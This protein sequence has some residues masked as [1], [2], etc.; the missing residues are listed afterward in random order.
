MGDYLAEEALKWIDCL[1][2]RTER[3]LERLRNTVA[4]IEAIEKCPED[5]QSDY[6]SCNH[7]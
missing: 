5:N 7:E 1:I 2:R 4:V 6:G 3:E